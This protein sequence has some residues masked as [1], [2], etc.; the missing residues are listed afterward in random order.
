MSKGKALKTY[1]L[2]LIFQ[3][4]SLESVSYTHLD[5]YKRQAFDR[6]WHEGLLYKLAHTP[7]PASTVRLFWSHLRGRTFHISVDGAVSSDRPIDAGVLQGSVL[8][9]VLYLSLIHI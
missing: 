3:W 1:F 5:V 7:L 2:A 6:V 9:P 4:H 8:G